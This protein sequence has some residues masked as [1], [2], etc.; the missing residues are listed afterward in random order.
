[1]SF[2]NLRENMEFILPSLA[3]L[4]VYVLAAALFWSLFKWLRKKKL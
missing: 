1:M 2:N 3:L 4:G